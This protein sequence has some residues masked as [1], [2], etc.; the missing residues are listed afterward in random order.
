LFAIGVRCVERIGHAIGR[1]S[2]KAWLKTK[3]PATL[4]VPRFQDEP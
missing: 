1:I 3:N 2:G 4:R